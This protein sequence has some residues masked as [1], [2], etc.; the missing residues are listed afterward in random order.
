[1]FIASYLN[2]SMSNLMAQTSE[3]KVNII[4]IQMR[5]QIHLSLR[6][7]SLNEIFSQT[8]ILS[9]LKRRLP[10]SIQFHLIPL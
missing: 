5:L 2:N 4:L 8:S 9:V 7:F 6:A 10:F 3:A 1:M